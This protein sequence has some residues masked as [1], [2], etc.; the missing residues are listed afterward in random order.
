MSIPFLFI[1]VF[2]PMSH[3][4]EVERYGGTRR[5]RFEKKKQTGAYASYLLHQIVYG[6]ILLDNIN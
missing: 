3:T 1:S 6:V 2:S 5:H 4:A